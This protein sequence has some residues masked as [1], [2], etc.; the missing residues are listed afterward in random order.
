MNIDTLEGRK[1]GTQSLL[2][3]IPEGTRK[4]N[5]LR[6]MLSDTDKS[7]ET[8]KARKAHAEYMTELSKTLPAKALQALM[9]L[10]IAVD[11]AMVCNDDDEDL[12][13]INKM[14]FDIDE[15]DNLMNIITGLIGIVNQSAVEPVKKQYST[16][17][18]ISRAE[19]LARAQDPENPW[20]TFC[21]KC[22][23]PMLASHIE[24][25]QK[26]T[27]ICV[28]I[29]AGRK[30]TLVHQDARDERIGDYVVDQVFHDDSGEE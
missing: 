1:T 25:H 22:S 14:I 16:R 27:S 12:N 17:N 6:K 8:Y 23:R 20:Y 29:K 11:S 2:D 24:E 28:E 4:G 15:E 26:S 3:L 10:Q 5:E 13:V 7:K 9:K 21:P 19:T 18:R 30:A